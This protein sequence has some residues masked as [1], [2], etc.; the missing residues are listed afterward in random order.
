MDVNSLIAEGFNEI[1][2]YPIIKRS[3]PVD[4]F[5]EVV[6]NCLINATL[7]VF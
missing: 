3:Q 1:C 7:S 4:I 6:S 2:K 5:G